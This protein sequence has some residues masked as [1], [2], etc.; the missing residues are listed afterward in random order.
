[1]LRGDTSTAEGAAS[2]VTERGEAVPSAVSSV[3]KCKANIAGSDATPGGKGP[4]LVLV[5]GTED[6][7]G[8]ACVCCVVVSCVTAWAVKPG[9]GHC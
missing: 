5:P 6:P 2:C 8:G 3:P 4:C 1:M 9:T 7:A